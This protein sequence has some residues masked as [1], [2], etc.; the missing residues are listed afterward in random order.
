MRRTAPTTLTMTT[1]TCPDTHLLEFGAPS[2]RSVTPVELHTAIGAAAAARLRG[3]KV[4]LA[5]A[6]WPKPLNVSQPKVAA[7]RAEKSR[8]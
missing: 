8:Q 7:K 6:H 5:H 2:R 1:T 3:V 4:G